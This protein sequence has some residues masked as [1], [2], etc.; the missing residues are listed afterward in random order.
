MF[1]SPAGTSTPFSVKDI[2]N[3][4]LE[5]RQEQQQEEEERRRRSLAAMELPGRL[6]A[7]L[8]PASC[9][10][11]AFKQEAYGGPE[12]AG[13]QELALTDGL[14]PAKHCPAFPAAFYG[15]NYAHME[16]AKEPKADKKG[17]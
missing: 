16:P 9:M 14:G 4:E 2:L 15:K 1:A 3:L 8:P 6:E 5:Q 17:K 11:A 10:L 13:L 7:S 12:T